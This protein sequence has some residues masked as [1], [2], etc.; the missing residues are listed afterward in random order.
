MHICASLSKCYIIFFLYLNINNNTNN[1]ITTQHS[2]S[3]KKKFSRK[4]DYYF[5]SGVPAHMQGEQLK[6]M[7]PCVNIYLSISISKREEVRTTK[8]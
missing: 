6:I 8:I 1:N 2:L 4:V 3:E 7:F 5:K